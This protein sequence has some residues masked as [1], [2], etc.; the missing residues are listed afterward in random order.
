MLLC[1][2]V[3]VSTTNL[4]LKQFNGNFNAC[5]C[6]VHLLPLYTSKMIMDQPGLWVYRIQMF[7]AEKRD[8]NLY[9]LFISVSHDSQPS[10]NKSTQHGTY[11][12]LFNLTYFYSRDRVQVSEF[13]GYN[14]MANRYDRISSCRILLFIYLRTNLSC[15]S[16]WM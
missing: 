16:F 15:Q 4:Q 8:N 2:K 5:I 3:A 11:D 7:N 9:E 13:L 12:Y 10:L 1:C 14:E 6:L